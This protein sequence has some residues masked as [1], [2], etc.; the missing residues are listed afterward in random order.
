LS[1]NYG[2]GREKFSAAGARKSRP[3]DDSNAVPAAERVAV[4]SYAVE[5]HDRRPQ[6][7]DR[8]ELLRENRQLREKVKWTET[9]AFGIL[10]ICLIFMNASP[11]RDGGVAGVLALL[12]AAVIWNIG[13]LLIWLSNRNQH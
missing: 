9:G 2:T 6:M 5:T 8:E 11:G 7:N 12:E 13:K 3:E 10:F 1:L 4:R